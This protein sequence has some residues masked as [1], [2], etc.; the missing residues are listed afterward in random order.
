MRGR[1]EGE[2]VEAGDR[3]RA[4]GE[5]VAQDAADAG[6][7]ALIGLDVARMVVALHLEHDGEPVADIDDAGILARPLDHPGRLAVGRVRRWIFEDLY[8]QCSFHMAE[9]MPSSVKLGVAA[10]QLRGCAR[11]SSGLS[12]WAA[13]SAG[14]ILI[15]AARS[16]AAL[17]ARAAG[18]SLALGLGSDLR[19]ALADVFAPVLADAFSLGLG[20]FGPG[21][22]G[23]PDGG[24]LR[25][26][27][28]CGCPCHYV[29]DVIAEPAH[30]KC[31]Q[32]ETQGWASC[33]QSCMRSI[34]QRRA[35]RVQ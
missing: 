9:K 16:F 5:D 10:D 25:P 27:P 13:T 23:A 2:R 34:P 35:R 19:L 29:L 18:L 14:V 15:G 6:G 28:L 17:A 12:P 8:E 3:P 24:R 26:G 4:H 21:C 7:R 33:A 1:A 20:L 32:L 22:L 30:H 11:Y 31:G